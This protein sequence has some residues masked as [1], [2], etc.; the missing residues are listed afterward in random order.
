MKI[1]F[2]SNHKLFISKH[3]T[4]DKGFIQIYKIIVIVY[5]LVKKVVF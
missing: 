2:L 5:I 3:R 4:G 1:K